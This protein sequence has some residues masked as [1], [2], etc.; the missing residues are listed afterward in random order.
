M[1]SNRKWRACNRMIVSH[2]NVNAYWSHIVCGALLLV[3]AVVISSLG[4]GAVKIDFTEISHYLLGDAEPQTSMILEQLRLPRALLALGVGAL[5]ASSG[6]VTQGLFRNPLADPSLIGVS[7][8]ATAGA[9]IVIVLLNHYQWNMWG[10]SLVS[11]GAI[12]GGA[13]SVMFVYRIA[14]GPSG[15]SVAT[16]LLAG[17]AMTF[18]AASVSSLLEFVADNEMLR[19][20][21]LWRMGGLDAANYSR[22]A[23]ILFTCVFILLL[24]PKYYSALNALLL[25]ES[26]ARH[27]G[28]SIDKVKRN[29]I[30]IVAMGVGV[31]VA[32]TGTIAFI[33]LVVPHMVR[34]FVGPNHRYLI[35]LSA[36]VGGLLLV[37]AD[38]F[39]RTIIAPT[40]LPVGLVT[41]IIG[42]PVFISL[43]RQR[44][45][46]GMQ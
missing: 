23:I 31:S 37:I 25:G 7:A 32:M 30:I 15:T 46:Y 40:E 3:V 43:L 16:M 41:A 19:R 21:S 4:F 45:H 29:I 22:V 9:S 28:I 5:L 8:G 26:E 6:A 24:L 18:I 17:I 44:H 20:L 38:A 1:R 13:I 11:V 12:L 27:L 34:F 10:L 42:A 35:P 39:A 36:C 33:G 14:T 2:R